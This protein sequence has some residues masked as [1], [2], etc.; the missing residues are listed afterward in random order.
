MADA[1]QNEREA[2][3][4]F[5]E[6]VRNGPAV[7]DI[8]SVV[9]EDTKNKQKKMKKL[10]D[11]LSFVQTF[12][13]FSF[14]SSSVPLFY[15]SATAVSRPCCKLPCVV[16]WREFAMWRNEFANFLKFAITGLPST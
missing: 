11:K 12:L 13:A 5:I 14:F 4:K 9:Y 1:S 16:V 3:F 7:W 8:S 2:T 10:A 6:E 15:V